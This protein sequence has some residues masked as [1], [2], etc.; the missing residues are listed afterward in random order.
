[1]SDCVVALDYMG[2]IVDAF[3]KVRAGSHIGFGIGEGNSISPANVRPH[4]MQILFGAVYSNSSTL[5]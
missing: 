5:L 2:I 4:C 3:G 1:M